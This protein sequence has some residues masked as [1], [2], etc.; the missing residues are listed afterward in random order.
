VPPTTTQVIS[1]DFL[2]T[3]HP[4]K[5]ISKKILISQACLFISAGIIWY[6]Y[7]HGQ[8]SL[9]SHVSSSLVSFGNKPGFA[10]Q[11]TSL[12]DIPV[13][14]CWTVGRGIWESPV[15]YARSAAFSWGKLLLKSKEVQLRWRKKICLG[16]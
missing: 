4:T 6:C 14:G 1:V 11:V 9:A 12:E 15:C 13:P 2:T 8:L 16:T 3:E 10:Y 7:S 5:F